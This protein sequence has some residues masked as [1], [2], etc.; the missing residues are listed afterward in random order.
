[1]DKRIR[2][3]FEDLF[4]QSLILIPPFAGLRRE[5]FLQKKS[6]DMPRRF[7][8]LFIIWHF[9]KIRIAYRVG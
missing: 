9:W 5:V 2:K 1:M 8:K 7:T 4:L 3:Q 6:G